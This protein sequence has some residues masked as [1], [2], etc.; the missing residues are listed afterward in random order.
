MLGRALGEL[1]WRGLIAQI[2]DRSGLEA[3]LSQKPQTLYCGF[4]PTAD[5]L[6]IGNLVPLLALRRFQELGHRP[7]VLVGGATG[8]IGDPTFRKDERALNSAEVV[9]GWARKIRRQVEPFLCFDGPNAAMVVDNLEWTANLDV[10]T[11]L[12]DIGKHFS[13]NSMIQRDSIRSRLERDG[14]GISFTEFSY[15]LLQGMDFLELARRYDCRLQIGGSDQWG[16]IVSGIPLIRRE[17]S[18]ES[19]GLTVPLV[20]KADGSKFGKTASGTIWLDA[21]KTSPY[22][23]YQFWLNTADAD[24][25]QYL[26]YFSFLS[27][28]EVEPLK[29]SVVQAPQARWAQKELARAVTKLVHGEQSLLRAESITAALF[30]GDLC[31][32]EESDISQLALDGMPVVEAPIGTGLLT[33][34]VSAGFAKSISAARSLVQSG[35]VSMNGRNISDVQ[36][37]LLVEEALFGRFY[38]VRKGKKSWF[39][40][41]LQK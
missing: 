25:V 13:V 38:L 22:S 19:F 17:L 41:I 6:H 24:V 16:N 2:S 1:E 35:A 4:D 37:V 15:M 5:S 3:H 34:I 7:I 27:E 26:Q 10:I 21:N 23:F 18:Q 36:K 33:G 8:L 9:E 40:I 29:E 39:L 11:F 32:L 28:E 12:R 20:T 31:D 30:N 14:Q